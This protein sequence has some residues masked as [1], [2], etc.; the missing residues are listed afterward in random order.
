[1]KEAI[2]KILKKGDEVISVFPY[3]ESFAVGVRRKSGIVDITIIT[4]DSQDF[5]IIGERITIG[6]GSD[7]IEVKAGEFSVE[8]F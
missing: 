3:G 4:R 2:I 8:S 6:E 7:A 5:P 1:L